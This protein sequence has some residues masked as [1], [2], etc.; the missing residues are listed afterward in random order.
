V[1]RTSGEQR[2]SNFLLWQGVAA[3]IAFPSVDWP[4]FDATA[5]A[6]VVAAFRARTQAPQPRVAARMG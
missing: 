4:D 2:L 3:E 6:E 5:L 1:I